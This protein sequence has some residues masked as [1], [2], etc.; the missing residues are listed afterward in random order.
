[1]FVARV[2][3]VLREILNSILSVIECDSNV[4]RPVRLIFQS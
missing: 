2:T 1:M 4:P 3:V